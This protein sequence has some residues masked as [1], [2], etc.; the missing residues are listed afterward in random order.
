[1]GVSMTPQ[2]FLQAQINLKKYSPLKTTLPSVKKVLRTNALI[3][4]QSPVN[5]LEEEQLFFLILQWLCTF[6]CP[7][8]RLKSF[9]LEQ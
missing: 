4:K 9:L 7:H 5:T 6:Y 8:R 2:V 3:F 1:M